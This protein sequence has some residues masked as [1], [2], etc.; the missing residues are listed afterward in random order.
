MVLWLSYMLWPVALVVAAY[1]LDLTARLAMRRAQDRLRVAATASD[2]TDTP[3]VPTITSRDIGV[4]VAVALGPA[5]ALNFAAYATCLTSYGFAAHFTNRGWVSDALLFG[6]FAIAVTAT[7]AHRLVVISI[8]ARRTPRAVL[9]SEPWLR[10]IGLIALLADAL[11]ALA[12]LVVATA[13][14]A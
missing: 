4:L 7:I 9:R 10:L 11:T 1:G 12:W 13:P 2:D 6:Y 5:V 3:A 8:A 14:S